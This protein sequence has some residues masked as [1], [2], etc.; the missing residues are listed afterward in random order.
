MICGTSH[1]T[2]VVRAKT[3]FEGRPRTLELHYPHCCFPLF[4]GLDTAV[5][6]VLLSFLATDFLCSEYLYALASS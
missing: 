2:I 3:G 5:D 1:M 4:Q 6:G